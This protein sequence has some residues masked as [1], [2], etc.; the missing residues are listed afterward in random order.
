MTRY[1]FAERL[2][3][4]SLLEEV[5]PDA[6]TLCGTWKARDLVIVILILLVAMPAALHYQ[7]RQ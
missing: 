6:P 7:R 4:A 1:A 2:A 3:L 5:G